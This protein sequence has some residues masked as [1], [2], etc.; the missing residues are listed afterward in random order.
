[1]SYDKVDTKPDLIH[2]DVPLCSSYFLAPAAQPFWM[3]GKL[4]SIFL[5]ENL[6]LELHQ[7][8][9]KQSEGGS[10]EERLCFLT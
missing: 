4:V 3:H 6:L 8:I 5:P 10:G 2:P 9:P 1:M 7:S